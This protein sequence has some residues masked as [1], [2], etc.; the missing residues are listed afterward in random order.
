[1]VNILECD[2]FVS[3]FKLESSYDINFWTINFRK[4]MNHLIS[5]FT[6]KIVTQPFFYKDGL[7]IK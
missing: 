2:I 6:G 5:L 1:M 3:E 4:D 7:G